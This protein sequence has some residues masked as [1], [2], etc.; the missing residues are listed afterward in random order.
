MPPES[1]KRTQAPRRRRMA[2]FTENP[3]R[4]EL[5]RKA[6]IHLLGLTFESFCEV[7]PTRAQICRKFN[8]R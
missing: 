8:K 2:L 1:Q 7:L 3:L 5:W 6:A 4:R